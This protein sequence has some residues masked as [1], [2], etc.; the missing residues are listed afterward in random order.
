MI[1]V[2]AREFSERRFVLPL[3]IGFRQTKVQV[4]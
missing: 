1:L 3:H 2:D 4:G